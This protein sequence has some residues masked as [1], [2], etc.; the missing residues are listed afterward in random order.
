[1]TD[2]KYELVAFTRNVTDPENTTL[3]MIP[4][5]ELELQGPLYDMVSKCREEEKQKNG[6][7]DLALAK[8]YMRTYEK[9]A[10]LEFLLGHPK[11]GY[12]FLRRA[13]EYAAL[14]KE[15][16]QRVLTA[17]KRVLKPKPVL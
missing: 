14:Q 3:H 9:C 17:P 6:I 2:R 11:D 1:M 4:E 12:H 13:C 5:L 7:I 16:Q 15:L 8:K 10:R